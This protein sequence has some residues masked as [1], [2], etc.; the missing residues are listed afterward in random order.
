MAKTSADPALRYLAM[1]QLIP[2]RPKRISVARL[3]SKLAEKGFRVTP[4][5]VQRDLNRLSGQ[6]Y[7]IRC[8]AEGRMQHW[9]FI[10]RFALTQIP[11]MSDATALALKLAEDYLTAIMPPSSLRLLRPYFNRAQQVLDETRLGRWR[12]KVKVIHRG[13][14]LIPP[15][16]APGVQ[17]AVY[18]ALLDGRQLKAA[19]KSRG[20]DEPKDMVLNPLGVVVREGVIYLIATALGVRGRP[21]FRPA[22]FRSRERDFRR[23]AR[24]PRVQSA[25][26]RRG[27]RGV[28]L[29]GIAEEDPAESSGGRVSGRAPE[30]MPA[31]SGP[32]GDLAQGRQ[33]G[34]H[35]DRRGHG[36]AAL[37]DPR[38]RLAVPR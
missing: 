7:P 20:Q 13:P 36:R 28:R 26:A 25:E 9:C 22:P 29:P 34:A 38:F 14:Q 30:G 16:I 24:G 2:E 27:G 33:I 10:D 31:V 19:Y 32:D 15:K 12:N 3:R 37:V 21:P 8:D 6:R 18:Q 17:E 23:R 35:R 11:A 1:L 4:R 5:T